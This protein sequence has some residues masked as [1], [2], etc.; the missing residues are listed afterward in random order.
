MSS[1]AGLPSQLRQIRHVPT[2][3]HRFDEQYARIHP[4][5][6]DVDAVPPV[7]QRGGLRR[8]HLREGID[9]AGVTVSE[10]LQRL[11]KAGSHDWQPR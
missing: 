5:S 4:A 10:E 7:A 2:A 1:G 9:A 8:D 11:L 6:K 3:A